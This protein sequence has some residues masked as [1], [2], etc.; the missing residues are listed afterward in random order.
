MGNEQYMANNPYSIN[1]NQTPVNSYMNNSPY[2]RPIDIF[3]CVNG[4]NGMANYPIPM[5]RTGILFDFPNGKFWLKSPG[6]PQPVQEFE[7]RRVEY[8]N[9]QQTAIPQQTASTVTRDEFESA[10]NS[11]GESMNDLKEI[12]LSLRDSN[13]DNQPRPA[14]KKFN[15]QKG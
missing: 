6:G 5:G 9:A 13:S 10:I 3:D 7:F 2:Q 8:S 15:S 4:Y 12:V 14:N 1:A 11:L